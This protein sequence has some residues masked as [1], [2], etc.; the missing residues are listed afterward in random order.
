LD[1]VVLFHVRAD[2]S[3]RPAR[4]NP[5]TH[6]R[7]ISQLHISMLLG[8]LVSIREERQWIKFFSGSALPPL[9]SDQ[10]FVRL[11]EDENPHVPL[12]SL[13]VSSPI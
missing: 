5:K 8:Y 13:N 12:T 3:W 10:N 7:M 4:K 9:S 1:T 6:Q 11:R 2:P